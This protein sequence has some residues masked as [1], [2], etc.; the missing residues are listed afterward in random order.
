MASKRNQTNPDATPDWTLSQQQ[1]T[2]IDL[3]VTGNTLQAVADA[4]G[5]QRPTVSQWVTHHPGFQAE[6][7]LRRQ[8]LWADLVDGLRAL[9][10]KAMEVLKAELEGETPLQAAIHVLKAC[11]LYGGIAA[12]RGPTDPRELA[13]A[14]QLADD[15]RQHAAAEAALT[16]K[17]K[18]YDRYLADMHVG[19]IGLS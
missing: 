16:I 19:P 2:A 4:I 11:G 7:N 17:R 6:V 18:A 15:A 9:A 13:A 14:M 10:P 12:P 5:V 8:Q 1:L 3:L